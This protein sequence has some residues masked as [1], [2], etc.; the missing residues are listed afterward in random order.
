MSA[1]GGGFS[2]ATGRDRRPGYVADHKRRRAFVVAHL[3]QHGEQVERGVW[4]ARCQV[5]GHVKTLRIS[6]YWADHVTPV[7][8][9][10][11]EH[12]PLQLSCKACQITQGSQVA[13]ARN[14]K[15]VPRKRPPEDHPG[16]LK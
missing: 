10:G 4:R 15:A 11:S 16:R 9:G 1:A 6:D 5:C 13:N 14:P 3:R 2:G 12:G 8:A 7:A